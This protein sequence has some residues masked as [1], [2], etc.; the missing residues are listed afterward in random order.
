MAPMA[1]PS[2]RRRTG[3]VPWD[4]IPTAVPAAAAAPPTPAIA[5]DLC[6]CILV[7]TSWPPLLPPRR[8]IPLRAAG[9]DP[10]GF[11]WDCVYSTTISRGA[12]LA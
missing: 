8:F 11:A 2:H 7:P 9:F 5:G 1:V 10:M 4:G 6:A 12:G 3:T